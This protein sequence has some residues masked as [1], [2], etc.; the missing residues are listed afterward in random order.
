MPNENFINIIEGVN[1]DAAL[2]VSFAAGFGY[3]IS[4]VHHFLF[5]KMS[6]YPWPEYGTFIKELQNKHLLKFSGNLNINN[7]R[8][9]WRVINIIW[10]GLRTDYPAIERINARNDSLTDLQHSNGS[11]LAALVISLFAS[12]I[13]ILY[14]MI[15]YN[16]EFKC[17]NGITS[18]VII[19]LFGAL[20]FFHFCSY[21]ASVENVQ[22]FVR[23]SLFH[24]LSNWKESHNQEEYTFHMPG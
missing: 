2:L 13:L 20:L 22:E 23:L 8:E 14:I 3:I 24:V 9:L 5:H 12:I 16:M 10:H 15:R 1:I 21:K 7:E 6:F 11:V 17:S 19:L 18:I 4:I